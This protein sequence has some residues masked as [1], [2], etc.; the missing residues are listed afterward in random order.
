MEGV[1]ECGSQRTEEE[2]PGEGPVYVLR[3]EPSRADEHVLD[4]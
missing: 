4:A 2:G 3:E 1:E